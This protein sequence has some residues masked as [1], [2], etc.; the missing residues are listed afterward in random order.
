MEKAL[1]SVC[2]ICY[3]QAAFIRQALDSVLAQKVNFSWEIIIADDCSTDGTREI[4]VDYQ[5][6]YP[7]LIRVLP[8]DRNLGPAK[9]FMNLI[10]SAGG[11][12]I[13]YL[14]GD[15]YWT[16]DTKLRQQV[17]FLEE[18][19]S[20][21]ICCTDCMETYSEDLTDT[22]NHLFN[23]PGSQ[24]ETSANELIFRNY[25]QTCTVVFRNKLFEKFPDW[26]P[27]LKIGD[28]P[29][30]LLNAQ[31]GAIKFIPVVS[32]VH[33]N[34]SSG[35]WSSRNVLSRTYE[36]ISMF[37]KLERYTSLGQLPNFK[38]SKSNIYLSSVKYHLRKGDV[39]R[40]IRNLFKGVYIY[41]MNL[42]NRKKPV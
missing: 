11:K 26:Y 7:G 13:A 37:D 38:R 25:I 15:D 36:I 1:L 22:A 4:V 32:A 24:T 23:G 21:A 6:R 14:E 20:F 39:V 34:H 10:N 19:P 16:L 17:D 3:N 42:L 41:P 27:D 29:L 8:R 28:W 30:H 33:R 5:S 18:H 35:V 2:F 40:A 9:N 12:Y 31:Y